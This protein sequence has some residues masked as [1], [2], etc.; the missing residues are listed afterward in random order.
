MVTKKELK[1]IKQAIGL[2]LI[3]MLTICAIYITKPP[4]E[5]I[6]KLY[7]T[8]TKSGRPVIYLMDNNGNV[9]LVNERDIQLIQELEKK[10]EVVE[11]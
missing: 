4:N 6:K 2:I 1:L 7:K 8:S 5:P 9:E 3:V 11:K 10:F